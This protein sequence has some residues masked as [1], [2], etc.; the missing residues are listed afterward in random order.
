MSKQNKEDLLKG[1]KSE[2]EEIIIG[3]SSH[4]DYGRDYVLNDLDIRIVSNRIVNYIQELFDDPEIIEAMTSEIFK[5]D[6]NT[7]TEPTDS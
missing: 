2:V 1:W 6:V 5:P 4:D 3:Q 7:S